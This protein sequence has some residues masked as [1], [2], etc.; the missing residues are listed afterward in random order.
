MIK[1]KYFGMLTEITLCSEEQLAFSGTTVEELLKLIVTKH[2]GLK[3]LNFQV[4]QNNDIVDLTA[5]VN[6]DLI[7]LLP[8]FAGG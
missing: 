2:P 7:A 6:A 4:A 3:S 8:P 5:K 1:V